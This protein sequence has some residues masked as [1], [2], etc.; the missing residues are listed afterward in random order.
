VFFNDDWI[1][2]AERGRF[3]RDADI[4]VSCHLPHI[5]TRYAFRT[6]LLDCF[7]AGLPM[8]VTEG[9]VLADVVRREDLGVVVPPEDVGALAQGVLTLL[10]RVATDEAGYAARFAAVRP[11]MRW[12]VAVGP[13]ARFLANPARAAD[14]GTIADPGRG[15]PTPLGGLGARAIELL[16]EGGPLLLAEEAVR[17]VRWLRRPH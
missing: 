14:A 6:R 1:P 15:A 9:D 16:R 3:L 5:E 17:Y 13:L 2:Y 8:L 11:A 10:E 4:G 7:W 12:D